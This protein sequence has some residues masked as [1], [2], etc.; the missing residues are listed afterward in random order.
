MIT[1]CAI[2]KLRLP[3]WMIVST[4]CNSPPKSLVCTSF[5]CA[6]R[7]STSLGH[8]F[9]LP[10]DLEP[11]AVPIECMPVDPVWNV[12]QSMKNVI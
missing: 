4:Q 9:S 12:E 6:T 2:L 10:L 5:Q 11:M 8:L 7:T 3:T 1:N